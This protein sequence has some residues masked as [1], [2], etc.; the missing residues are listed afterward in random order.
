M[1]GSPTGGHLRRRG[2]SAGPRPTRRRRCGA[3]A[4]RGRRARAAR[5]RSAPGP[6]G[7]GRAHV[8]VVGG[9]GV[10][11][12]QQLGDELVL[13]QGARRVAGRLVVDR[14]VGAGG[15]GDG[16]EGAEPV[17][18]EDPALPA[19]SAAIRRTECH[20]SWASPSVRAGPSRSGR[21]TLPCSIEPPV[22]T[23]T[24]TPSTDKAYDRWCGV[25]PGVCR[26]RQV[27]RPLAKVSP[28]FIRVAA[29]S[30]SA[31]PASRRPRPWC[32]PARGLRSRSRC[33]YASPGRG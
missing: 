13:V 9:E 2:A 10:Q 32:G 6:A 31:A 5:G 20:W 11:A 16:A 26:A 8:R 21:P 19:T 17:G 1:T 18:G 24:S 7:V 28:S 4:R 12:G 3:A 27:A 22:K 25:C 23:P 33:G 30:N 15:G 14:R 29:K